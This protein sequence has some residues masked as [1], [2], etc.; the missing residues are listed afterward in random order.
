[1]VNY[2][3][4]I[5]SIIIKVKKMKEINMKE[6]AANFINR[7]NNRTCSQH[8]S[9]T[10]N[11][12]DNNAGVEFAT[13]L[14]EYI[15]GANDHNLQ[16]AL[17]YNTDLVGVLEINNFFEVKAYVHALNKKAEINLETRKYI[18]TALHEITAEI[19]KSLS[20]F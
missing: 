11:N 7:I 13:F 2:N 8:D 16:I 15:C 10:A 14:S 1:M 9:V 4:I 20:K 12:F 3:E 5:H 18:A 6:V 19:F 17:K